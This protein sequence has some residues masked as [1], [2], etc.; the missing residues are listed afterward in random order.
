M[1]AQ[2]QLCR[3]ADHGGFSAP[4]ADEEIPAELATEMLGGVIAG[5]D[6]AVFPCPDYRYLGEAL[7]QARRLVS[8]LKVLV[9]GAG[10]N[11][12]GESASKLAVM[13][14]VKHLTKSIFALR[15]PRYFRS[16][17]HNE[18]LFGNLCGPGATPG[19]LVCRGGACSRLWKISRMLFLETRFSG[20][21]SRIGHCG[22]FRGVCIFKTCQKMGKKPAPEVM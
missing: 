18:Q 3:V 12:R 14:R 10:E 13:G 15:I 16:G 6:V 9:R 20:W 7:D 17:G 11:G 21:R 8:D 22:E 19:R 5:T 4:D 2:K 1:F